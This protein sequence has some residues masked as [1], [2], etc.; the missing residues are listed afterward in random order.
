M[1]SVGA[2]VLILI[3]ISTHHEVSMYSLLAVGLMNSIMFATIFTLAVAGLG[4]HTEEASGLLNVA[5][6]GGALVPLL[7]GKIADIS[8]LQWALLL[9]IVCYAYIIWYGMRG[10]EPR[11]ASYYQPEV[12]V[13]VPITGL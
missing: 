4:W 12:P 5:I 10:Y 13:Q 3:S 7:F 1:A 11:M 2:I 6:V 9:P 8:S